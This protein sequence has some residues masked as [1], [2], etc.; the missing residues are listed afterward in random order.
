[1]RWN[2]KVGCFQPVC[3]CKTRAD[4]AYAADQMRKAV[5]SEQAAG[6]SRVKEASVE[7]QEQELQQE[8]QAAEK[9]AQQSDANAKRI[10]QQTVARWQ[11]RG[12]HL[13]LWSPSVRL[14]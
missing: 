6:A 12:E 13:H 9:R 10:E 11:K 14:P 7:K 3:S 8:E 1:M 2:L 4:E 5:A